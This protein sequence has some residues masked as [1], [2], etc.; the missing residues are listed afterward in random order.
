MYKEKATLVF[1]IETIPDIAK[2]KR[3]YNLEKLSDDEAYEALKNIRRQETGGSDFFRH[4]FHKVVC[5]SVVLRMGDSVRVWSLGEEN[6]TESEIIKRFFSAIDKYD[7]TLVSWN[8]TGF[9]LPVLHYRAMLHEVVAPMYWELGDHYKEFRYNNYINRFHMRHIDLMDVL[10]LYQTRAAQSLDQIATFLG[11]PGKMGMDGSQ[12]YEF[13]QQGKISQIRH[14]C[15][16]DVLNTW[17]IY[18]RFQLMRGEIMKPAYQQ[19]I[20]LLKNTLASSDK[21]HL[22]DFLDDWEDEE[23]KIYE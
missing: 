14:Y 11:F 8:G 10:S 15:E 9:D 5:I 7:V 4:H 17:L 3:V 19:E 22:L 6:A 20:E 16:S 2:A 21:D 23:A 13:Y 18:L 1:D 12:V